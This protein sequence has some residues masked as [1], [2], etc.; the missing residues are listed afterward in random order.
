MQEAN[1]TRERNGG[2]DQNVSNDDLVYQV[3]VEL[4]S[5]TNKTLDIK[6]LFDACLQQ[7]QLPAKTINSSIYNLIKKKYIVEGSKL[8]RQ[9]ILSNE[10]RGKIYSYVQGNPGCRVRD[11]R[12]EMSIDNAE[13]HWHLKMLEKFGFLRNKR[14]GK[15]LCYFDASFPEDHD[16]ILCILRHNTTYNVFYDIFLTPNST[17]GEIAQRLGIH[18]STVKYHVDKL[19]KTALVHQSSDSG[20]SINTDLWNSIVQMAPSFSG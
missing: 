15:Y 5:R 1:S 2:S 8:T 9:D 13:S 4:I 17:E 12:R 11:I 3:A 18:P 16:E 10:L 6:Q 20:F 7:L 14:F 19:T